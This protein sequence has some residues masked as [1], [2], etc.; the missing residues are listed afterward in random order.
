ML[1]DNIVVPFAI[2]IGH[3]GVS[4]FIQIMRPYPFY[5][6]PFGRRRNRPHHQA[7]YPR[8]RLAFCILGPLICYIVRIRTSMC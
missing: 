5:V 6:Y 1:A 3:E 4:R 8:A 2:A 7:S